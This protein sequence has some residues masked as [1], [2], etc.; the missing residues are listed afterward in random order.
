MISPTKL[1]GAVEPQPQFD[2]RECILP[3]DGLEQHSPRGDWAPA[4]LTW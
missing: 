4:A 1:R 2:F 3:F